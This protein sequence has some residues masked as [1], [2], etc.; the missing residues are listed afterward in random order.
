MSRR[1]KKVGIAGRLGARYGLSARK[2]IRNIETEQ[3]KRHECPRCHHV[4]V[5]RES[6]GIWNCR[7]C[8]LRFAGG[9]YSP[10]TAAARSRMSSHSG[11]EP[12]QEEGARDDV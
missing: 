4:A 11:R 7:H 12:S 6:T 9:A 3:R 5:K 10:T 1:T 2:Q 8:D